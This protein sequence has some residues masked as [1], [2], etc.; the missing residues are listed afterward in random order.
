MSTG[1]RGDRARPH[2]GLVVVEIGQNVAAPMAGQAFADLGAEVI[3]VEKADGDDARRWG[4]PFWE[5]ASAVFQAI[6]RNK[7]SVVVDFGSE[8]DVAALRALILARADVVIQSMRPGLLEQK[9]LRADEVLAAKPSLVW[10]DLGAFGSGGPLSEQPGYDPLMQA[11]GGLMSVTGEAGRPPVRTGYPVVDGST[12]LWAVIA[13]QAALL[14]RAADGRG[15]RVEVSLYETALSWMTVPAAQYLAS[16][17]LP[18]QHGSGTEM[19]VPY[20]AFPTADG[21]L[22]VAAGN[23]KLFRKLCAA[24]GHAEWADDARFTSNAQRVVNRTAIDALIGDAM[25]PRPSAHWQAVL[26]AADVPF[27]AVQTVAQAIGHP[28]TEAIGMLQ[29]VPDSGMRLVAAPVRFD[30]DRP[31]IRRAAP[32]LGADAA[33]LDEFRSDPDLSPP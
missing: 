5:G 30:G 33:L 11:S 24:L 20:R 12:G 26:G 13:I 21:W 32:A 19:I 9:G 31:A 18:A 17:N 22:V 7:A 1:D 23:D 27:A 2:A 6:N 14:R 15:G 3:K 4:P 28:Q 25:A 8:R 29:P 10:C 16:G